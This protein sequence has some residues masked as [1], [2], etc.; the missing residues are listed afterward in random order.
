MIDSADFKRRRGRL[1]LLKATGEVVFADFI[2]FA[3][4][5]LRL[6]NDSI[7][8]SNTNHEPNIRGVNDECGESGGGQ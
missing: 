2:L 6:K 3:E 5:V 4:K 8:V 7:C 1:V